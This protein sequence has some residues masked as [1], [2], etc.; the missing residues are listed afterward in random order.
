[1][2][3]L[4][5]C[6]TRSYVKYSNMYLLVV[7]LTVESSRLGRDVAVFFQVESVVWKNRDCQMISNFLLIDGVRS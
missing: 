2:S 1:M 4:L 6:A 3:R 7:L 5:S